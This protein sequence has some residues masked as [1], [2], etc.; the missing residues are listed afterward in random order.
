M[1][2]LGFNGFRHRG[3]IP[4]SVGESLVNNQAGV[5]ARAEESA[6]KVHRAA[7]EYVAGA[8]DEECWRLSGGSSKRRKQEPPIHCQILI[9]CQT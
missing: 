4:E 5:H 3:F 9:S 2:L 7:Q 8:V 6:V 1:A